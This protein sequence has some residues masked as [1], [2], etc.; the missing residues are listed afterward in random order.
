MKFEYASN[1]CRRKLIVM[2]MMT[3]MPFIYVPQGLR[4]TYCRGT[5][6]K[7]MGGMR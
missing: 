2:I 5:S 3:M 4:E 1:V 6:P 7:G